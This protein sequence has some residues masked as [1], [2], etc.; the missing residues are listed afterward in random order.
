MSKG[1][2]KQGNIV[3]KTLFAKMIP[4]LHTQATLFSLDA[5]VDSTVISVPFNTCK[6]VNIHGETMLQQCFCVCLAVCCVFATI[7]V[8]ALKASPPRTAK[9]KSIDK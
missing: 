6:Q 8:G 3:V 2:H 7:F 4:C 5:N 9:H 1:H